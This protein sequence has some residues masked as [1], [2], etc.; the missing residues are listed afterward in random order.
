MKRTGV[1]VDTYKADKFREAFNE[2]KWFF[3]EFPGSKEGVT[4]FK[5]YVEDDEVRTVYEICKKLELAF[6]NQ[7]NRKN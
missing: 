1:V 5:L 3:T 2:K 6:S 4:V 7:K